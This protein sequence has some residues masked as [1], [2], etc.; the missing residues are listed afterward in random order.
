MWQCLYIYI[1]ELN[2]LEL[3]LIH[4]SMHSSHNLSTETAKTHFEEKNTSSK[5]NRYVFVSYL[6]WCFPGIHETGLWRSAA[7]SWTCPRLTPRA[8]PVWIGRFCLL[9]QHHLAWSILHHAQPLTE[10]GAVMY[11]MGWNYRLTLSLEVLSVSGVRG[12]NSRWEEPDQIGSGSGW[13][14]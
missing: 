10:K 11:E 2:I 9:R 1:S 13:V 8:A 14:T 5:V 3:L 12:Q 6:Q 4:S 7:L